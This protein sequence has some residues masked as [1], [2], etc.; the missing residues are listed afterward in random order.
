MTPSTDR[1]ARARIH[2]AISNA[3]SGSSVGMDAAVRQPTMRLLNTSET[4][5]VN[6][7]PDQVGT[8]VKSTTQR[9][10]GRSARNWRLTRS[11]G[12][13][14]VLSGRVV[15]NCLPRRTPRSLA[16]R[17][18]RSTV[19]RATGMPSRRSC[20]HTFSAPYRPRPR[21]RS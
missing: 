16:L 7:I 21:R 6:A 2:S 12:R 17:I 19:Q 13:A 15:T 11:A 5:A 8:Y 4:N 14:A 18:N 1:P 9:A 20:S 3:S 10:L